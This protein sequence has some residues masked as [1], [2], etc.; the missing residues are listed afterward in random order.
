MSD[1]TIDGVGSLASKLHLS[2]E[3]IKQLQ[4]VE[5]DAKVYNTWS[6]WQLSDD[7]ICRGPEV[8]KYCLQT[9]ESVFGKDN[10]LQDLKSALEEDGFK[11]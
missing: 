8:V 2:E 7:I 6:K 9:I 1:N 3:E 5:N 10:I 11:D 4:T